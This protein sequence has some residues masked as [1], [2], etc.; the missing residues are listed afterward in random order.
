MVNFTK[1]SKHYIRHVACFKVNDFTAGLF[2]TPFG[3]KHG[4]VLSPALSAIRKKTTSVLAVILDNVV[5][6][7]L[8]HADD[9]MLP[10]ESGDLL[11]KMLD[12]V[13]IRCSKWRLMINQS[14]T[15]IMRLRKNDILRSLQNVLFRAMPLEYTDSYK[16]LGFTLDEFITFEVGIG[17]LADSTGRALGSKFSQIYFYTDLHFEYF[18]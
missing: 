13:N 9:I 10:A 15:Q 17:I 14:K 1:L 11:Q 18:T 6:G 2:L 5:R 4:D 8:L 7:C 12:I 16:Y 3:V